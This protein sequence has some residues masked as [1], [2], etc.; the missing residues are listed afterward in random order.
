MAVTTHDPVKPAAIVEAATT[1]VADKLVIAN[2]FTS[3]SAEEFLGKAGDTLT[4]RIPG[5]LPFRRWGFRND[6]R[7]ALRVDRYSETTVDMRV[8]AEWLYS[9]LEM[10]PEQKQFDFAGSW[11]NLF[12]LQTDAISQGFEFDAYQ[13]LL[14]A[15]YERVKV[16]S[17]TR[18]EIIAAKEIGQD[19]LFNEFVD[20]KRDLKRMRT[21]DDR[22]VCIAGSA[23]IAELIKSNKLIRIAGGGDSAFASATVGTYAGI[24]FV[25]GPYTME[26]NVAFMYAPSGFL[27][28]NAAPPIPDGP[29]VYANANKNG[30]S[31]QWIKD[32]DPAFVASR[33]IFMTWKA[34]N[35]AKDFISLETG[36]GR[37]IQSPDQYF[38]RGVKI[39]LNGD[40]SLEKEPGDG[41]DDTP[42]GNPE[43]FLALA[44]TGQLAQY[45]ETDG[46]LIPFE[47]RAG[48]V[49]E[50][51]APDVTP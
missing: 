23:I 10:T 45:T 51:V 28:W 19:H 6:R 15:P 8:S 14:N 43:S 33:S 3:F 37:T 46:P 5:S 9:A 1:A 13:Q 27:L 35:Y 31:L 44:Y 48:T 7:E 41:K 20:L 42:G 49:T 34:S 21:P 38:L 18:A 2:S 40:A 32:Y 4:K 12:N 22:F 17:N 11:G 16:I 30:V 50:N 39:V 36:T 24:T 26:P 47:L 25:E 29:G